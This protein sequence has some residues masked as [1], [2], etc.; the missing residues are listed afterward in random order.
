M[1]MIKSQL[2]QV[3]TSLKTHNADAH[4]ASII[5]D[6][7]CDYPMNHGGHRSTFLNHGLCQNL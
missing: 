7:G 2:L 3:V 6:M 5:L 4:L 1:H